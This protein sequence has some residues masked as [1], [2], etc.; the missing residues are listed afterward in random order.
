VGRLKTV[1]S[2]LV[3]REGQDRER[4]VDDARSSN[5]AVGGD[6]GLV[7]QGVGLGL[8]SVVRHV[9]NGGGPVPEFPPDSIM[10]GSEIHHKDSGG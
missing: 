4:E 10:H 1:L 3:G 2:S 8:G 5:E 9:G 7:V 6:G